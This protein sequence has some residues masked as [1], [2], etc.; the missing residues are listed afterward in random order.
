[1]SAPLTS[2]GTT[3]VTSSPESASG[4]TP[5]ASPDG[6]TT[7]PS[8][9]APARA[10]RSARPAKVK[11]PPM[12]A[13][14]GLNG[15]GSSASVALS[16]SLASRLARQFAT[17]GSTLFRQTWKVLTTP[18]GRQ[19]WAHTASAHRTFGNDSTSSAHW[20]TPKAHDGEFATP[21]TTGRPMHRSTHLQT[22]AVAQLVP[23]A[24]V[25][26][27]SWP[28]ATV[29][30]AERG[31]QAKRAMGADRHGSNLQDFALLASW[32]TPM[33]GTP[34]QKGYNEAGNTDS[35]RKTVEV[36]ALLGR[37]VLLAG[38]ATPQTADENHARGTAEYAHRT[39]AREMPPSNNALKAHLVSG[40]P[41]TGSPASTE[42]RGQL[43]PAHSRWLMGLP[44]EWDACAPTGTRSTRSKPQPSSGRT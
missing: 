27:A 44:P 38:W 12:P 19:C 11:E 23:G 20:M 22:Q 4:V 40:P 29:H 16:Q 30:D 15:S 35:S 32:P 37:Q 14:C 10:S 2:S 21:R 3:N 5:C 17:A 39:M 24:D 34:A 28:T 1:M 42:K 43:N 7:G 6:Q 31:G 25:T 13:T 8:G 26:L 33:A 36:N 18:S 9:P 41:A